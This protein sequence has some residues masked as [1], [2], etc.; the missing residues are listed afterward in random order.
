MS[1]VLVTG[2]GSF[3]GYHVVKRLNQSGIRPRVLELPGSP[4][5]VLARLDVER[6]PGQLGDAAAMRQACAGAETLLHLAFKVSMGG[7]ALYDEMRRVNVDGS[8]ALLQAAAENGVRRA[9]VT[10]SALAVGVNKE[11]APLAESADWSR[12]AFDLPYALVRREAEIEARRMAKPGFDVMAVCPSFTFGPDD[13]TG[14]PANK[15]LERIV[16]GKQWFSLRVGFGCLDVRDF[17]QGAILA[18][19][20]GVSGERYLLSGENITADE[21]IARVKVIAGSPEA[22]VH[23]PAFL[24]HGLVGALGV[25]SRLKGKPPAATREVLQVLGRYAWYDT[26]KARAD[27]GWTPR[28]LDETLRDTIAWIRN[29]GAAGASGAARTAAR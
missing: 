1:T 8:R 20:R 9:V 2:A 22:K 12:H 26:S 6:C 5:E 16:T 4:P 15:L 14:A 13:P 18:S 21:L 3:L 29:P 17:A 28:P 27:L 25:V 11:A 23:L 24:L 19:E 10:G 7:G